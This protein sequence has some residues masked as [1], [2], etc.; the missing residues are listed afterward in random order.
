MKKVVILQSNYI[1][2]KGY[3]DLIKA[4]D[5][6]IL[7]DEVQYTKNDWRN[8]NKIK[9][10]SGLHWLAI[11]AKQEFLAQRILDTK[12]MDDRWRKKHFQTIRQFYA[13]ANCFASE[14]EFVEDLYATCAF[15]SISEINYHFI[16]R[17]SDRLGITTKLSWSQEYGLI[18][19][20][21][22]RLVDLVQKA[23]G[24]EYISGPAA[25]DYL[26]ESLFD[27]AG[28]KVTWADY[29]GYAEYT[30]VH[31]PFVHGVSVLD[32]L[33]NTGHEAKQYLKSVI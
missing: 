24:T 16:S 32:L 13:K 1:P 8:R 29:S 15:D 30:Q 25:K 12:V 18:E 31:S 17:I 27:A 3:F 28:I 26:D 19:G 14:I 22:E 10:P 5:E 33:I 11:P 9:S 6:F 2:W 23:G 20:K 4:A 21:T 7:Y